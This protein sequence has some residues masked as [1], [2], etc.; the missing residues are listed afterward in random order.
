M[1]A[2]KGT[3]QVVIPYAMLGGSTVSAASRL[4]TTS[5]KRDWHRALGEYPID[6]R[7]IWTFGEDGVSVYYRHQPPEASSAVPPHPSSPS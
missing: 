7:V 2:T 3:V 5:K 1:R 4:I 6:G